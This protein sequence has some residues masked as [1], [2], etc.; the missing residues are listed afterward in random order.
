MIDEKKFVDR[1]NIIQELGNLTRVST[2]DS[3]WS[4]PADRSV[5]LRN[6]FKSFPNSGGQMVQQ[7]IIPSI[8]FPV[9]VRTNATHDFYDSMDS[10]WIRASILTRMRR[11][12]NGSTCRLCAP[13][14]RNCSMNF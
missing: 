11:S 3:C 4:E 8:L 5:W 1:R 7:K 13:F 2:N 14:A 10:S 6:I 9:S 12:L